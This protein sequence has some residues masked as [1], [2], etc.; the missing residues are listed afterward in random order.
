[1][2]DRT[3]TA[4][5]ASL[6][7]IYLELQ[8]DP[9]YGLFHPAHGDVRRSPVLLCPPFG[10]AEACS[11]RARLEW[12]Y[13][14]ADRGHPTLRIDLPGTGDSAGDLTQGDRL[15]AW[16]QA[17]V[18]GVDWLRSHG[19]GGRPVA[20]IGIELGG[21]LALLAAA[22]G[23]PI[24]QLVLWG[25]RAKGS[26]WVRE[27]R[28]MGRL[29]DAHLRDAGAP[30]PPPLP[31]GAVVA[32][33]FVLDAATR[34][35]AE[36]FDAAALDLSRSAVRRVL[37]L[38]R[39]GLGVDE[40]LRDAL[41]ATGASVSV[42]PGAGFGTAVTGDLQTVEIP[43]ET[44]AQT[45]SWL[46]QAA[47]AAAATPAAPATAGQRLDLD[48]AGARVTETPFVHDVSAGRL[49]G[50]LAQPDGP[51][52]DVCAVLLNAGP[53][54]HVGPNR[55]WVQ[56]AR[57]WAA[58]GVPSLRV[59]LDGI[60]DA[61]GT[62]AGWR[63]EAAF[64]EPQHVD[65]V[66]DVLARLRAEG[67]A[68]RFLV[69]GLC[70]GASWAFNAALA[71]ESVAAALLINPRALIWKPWMET[72]REARKLRKLLRPGMWLRLVRGEIRVEVIGNVGRA[73][74]ARARRLPAAAVERLARRGER[75]E[76]DAALEQLA[77]QGT[78][79]TFIFTDEEPLYDELTREGRLDG[80]PN[81]Q[82]ATVRTGAN[83][84]ALQP[85]WV[86][87][88]VHRLMDDAL[89]RELRQTR[90]RTGTM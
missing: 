71:D 84:H 22:A 2:T 18:A 65:Y 66:S 3:Q 30:E 76:L 36:R 23:A 28:A 62:P 29:E 74:S 59:D 26:A 33:G 90:A 45:S 77:G 72:D 47:P 67:L 25:T 69:L 89:E 35:A 24:D 19:D 42:R 78:N 63:E 60:G 68:Q 87:A 58:R 32:G 44:F 53:Q 7:P 6:R 41:A 54:R 75:D 38:D 43:H 83:T 1:M 4:R 16:T 10:W 50:V 8:P 61:D 70:S 80:A 34:A 46:A 9:A 12:A 82:V 11:Y 14:L 40:R 79:L 15:G 17:I 39:D 20:A 13:H 48:V 57:R 52:A 56:S 27:L 81:L 64:Y 88:E 49:F 55:M 73:I 85:P 31:D 37:L 5:G 51:P 21:M 86:Q